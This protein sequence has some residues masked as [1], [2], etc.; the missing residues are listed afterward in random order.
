MV[1]ELSHGTVVEHTESFGVVHNTSPDNFEKGLFE[2]GYFVFIL[3]VDVPEAEEDVR[4][5][6]E[7]IERVHGEESAEKKERRLEWTTTFNA[8]GL[9]WKKHF[10]GRIPSRWSTWY[11]VGTDLRA[12]FA[13]NVQLTPTLIEAAI[14]HPHLA[15]AEDL[16]RCQKLTTKQLAFLLARPENGPPR[17]ENWRIERIIDSQKGFGL[18]DSEISKAL[19]EA[20]ELN[21]LLSDQTVDEAGFFKVVN[22]LK[23]DNSLA[24]LKR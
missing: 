20:N 3:E 8:R 4:A 9:L 17:K 21:R 24:S 2:N 10:S 11:N 1:D 7:W 18:S 5:V 16:S 22:D 19:V 12:A 13:Q 15:V 23:Q 6:K 14:A